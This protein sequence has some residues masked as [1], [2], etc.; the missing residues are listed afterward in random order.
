MV[1]KMPSSESKASSPTERPLAH[2]LNLPAFTEPQRE[3]W[4][5]RITWTQAMRLLAPTRDYYMQHFDSPEQRLRDKNPI[6]FR[7]D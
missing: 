3:H 5:M 2:D 6:P 7:L 1:G 4:P